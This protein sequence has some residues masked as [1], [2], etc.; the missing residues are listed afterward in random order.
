M[1]GR[2]FIQKTTVGTAGM[3]TAFHIPSFALN[4]KL[5]IGLIGCG[6]YGGVITTPDTLRATMNFDDVPLFWQHRLCD[7]GDLIP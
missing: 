6:W 7:T 3:P 4:K 2:S 1:K 5:K